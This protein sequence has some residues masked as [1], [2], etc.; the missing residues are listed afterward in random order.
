MDRFGML[1]LGLFAVVIGCGPAKEVPTTVVE[2]ETHGI[3]ADPFGVAPAES[4]PEAKALL[5]RAVKAITRGD[6]SRLEKAKGTIATFQGGVHFPRSPTITA[7][8]L[9]LQAL[10]P[11]RALVK[12]EF[13]EVIPTITFRFI[14][15]NGWMT[16]TAPDAVPNPVEVGQ[17]ILS[18]LVAKH[19]LPLGLT[20]ADPRAVAYAYEKISD[21]AMVKIGVPGM[22]ILRVT[23]DDKTDLPVK[24]EYN[25]VEIGTRVSKVSILRDHEVQGD[26]LL[27]TVIELTQDGRPAEKWKLEKWEFRES[28]DAA[29]FEAK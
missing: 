15:P 18:D 26:F 3:G 22:P 27:P 2:P 6:P 25:P 1:A 16:P 11:D 29:V 12:F 21:G 7:A 20:L 10:W 19:A 9:H 24:V 4:E 14:N 28:I 17:R 23:I 5:A 13:K 8:T